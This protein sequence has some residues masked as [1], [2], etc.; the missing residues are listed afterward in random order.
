MKLQISITVSKPV[1]PEVSI[2]IKLTP[3]FRNAD[4]GERKT[5]FCCVR[6]RRLFSAEQDGHMVFLKRI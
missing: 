6:H 3:P 1:G 4:I 2:S 5:C